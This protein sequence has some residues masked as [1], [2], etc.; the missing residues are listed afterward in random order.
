V[1]W[2]DKYY[3]ATVMQEQNKK[4]LLYLEYDDG[5]EEWVNL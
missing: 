3:E 5:D 1:L 2:D 4:R